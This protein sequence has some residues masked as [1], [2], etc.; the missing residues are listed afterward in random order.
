MGSAALLGMPAS[1]T[2]LNADIFD[3]ASMSAAGPF[4]A[5]VVPDHDPCLVDSVAEVGE[6]AVGSANGRCQ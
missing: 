5:K 3:S 1:L 4:A 2:V 6:G